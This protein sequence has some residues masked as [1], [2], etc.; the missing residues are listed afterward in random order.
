M[1]PW[2]LVIAFIAGYVA[3]RRVEIARNCPGPR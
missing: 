1:L 3:F 2:L